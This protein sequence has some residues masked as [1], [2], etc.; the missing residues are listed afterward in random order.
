MGYG[1]FYMMNLFAYITT[2]P[3]KLSACPNTVK[4]NDL[5]LEKISKECKTVIFCWGAFKQAEY[6]EKKMRQMFPDAMCFGRTPKGKPLHPLA[7]KIWQRS[8]FKYQKYA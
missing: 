8:K 5:W 7:A 4:D 1:G 2:D 6:R 3:K